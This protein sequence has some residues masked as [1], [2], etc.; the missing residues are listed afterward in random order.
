MPTNRDHLER[1]LLPA[2]VLLAIVIVVGV[3]VEARRVPAVLKRN[4]VAALN[5][6]GYRP[7]AITVDGRAVM[8]VGE[9]EAAADRSAILRIVGSIGG[10]RNVTDQ[11]HVVQPDT[12]SLS[13]SHV[14]D[15][16]VLAGA[17]PMDLA[18][19]VASDAR[20]TFGAS[21]VDNGIASSLSTEPP[22]W[23]DAYRTLMRSMAEVELPGLRIDGGSVVISGIVDSDSRRRAIISQA[24]QAFV[25]FS[26]E[27]GLEVVPRLASSVLQ[28]TL[29]ADSV[30]VEG[31]LQDDAARQQVIAAIE[32]HYPDRPIT[33]TMEAQDGIAPADWLAPLLALLPKL[34][35]VE[36]LVIDANDK[37]IKFSG[38][39]ENDAVY[40]QLDAAI[41]GAISDVDIKN[42]IKINPT[43]RVARIRFETTTD[44]I[45][46]RGELAT[47]GAINSIE[48]LLREYMPGTRIDN[49]MRVVEGVADIAT[50]ENFAQLPVTLRYIDE[51]EIDYY[52][53]QLVIGG[54]VA[55]AI[56]RE[57]VEADVRSLFPKSHIRSRVWLVG[58]VDRAR[59]S[60]RLSPESVSVGGV[61]ASRQDVNEAL[62]I[63]TALYSREQID[64][65]LR[66]DDSLQRPAWLSPTLT[67]LPLFFG[68]PRATMEVSADGAIV[69]GD[70]IDTDRKSALLSRLGEVFGSFP[71]EDGLTVATLLTPPLLTL[72]IGAEEITVEGRVPQISVDLMAAEL[73]ELFPTKTV[74]LEFEIG[75]SIAI[76]GELPAII[77][78]LSVLDADARVKVRMNAE[79]ISIEGA[80]PTVAMRDSLIANIESDHFNVP[81]QHRLTLLPPVPTTVQIT[82]TT[83]AV[84]V[85]GVVASESER[86]ALIAAARA[87]FNG[88]DVVTSVRIGR[89]T[90]IPDWRDSILALIRELSPIQV[91]ELTMGQGDARLDGSVPSAEAQQAVEAALRNAAE[92]GLEVVHAVEVGRRSAAALGAALADLNIGSIEFQIN[93][94]ALTDISRRAV[95]R[96][97]ELLAQY[98]GVTVEIGGHTD[99]SG[100]AA[101]NLKLSHRRAQSV[102][103]YLTDSGVDPQRLRAKGYGE[104]QPIA[105][106]DTSAGKARNRRI[107]F[108]VLES[109][110]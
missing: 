14:D 48:R 77:D 54:T 83:E 26:L 25:E 88:R 106:N 59:L 84:Q 30:E 51:L 5:A 7:P 101:S 75:D 43:K 39:V 27:D 56:E 12:A 96:V 23:I 109:I 66:V 107:E 110:E 87:G 69:T 68:M 57:R 98:P 37:N 80:L 95:R 91:G 53:N 89:R 60:Y 19:A 52:A 63:L 79:G 61:L 16:I 108:N 47:S 99:A 71:V 92:Q 32:N 105:D 74:V 1:M 78:L 15:R 34:G 20:R 6:E 9:V 41:Q 72:N 45:V 44:R 17:L 70:V 86:D 29:S 94:A 102:Q 62:N 18:N 100:S 73:P 8:L 21:R 81:V 103:R 104:A 76:P 82:I 58:A 33:A 13:L 2:I 3:I 38:I 67:A 42:R 46:L 93:S 36:P 50:P 65:S 35:M 28:I 97:A 24:Q 49:K 11:L 40:R 4:V 31:T 22:E 64:T 10:V 90:E 55:T 85:R